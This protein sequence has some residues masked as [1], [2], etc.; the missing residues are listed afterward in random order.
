MFSTT[1]FLFFLTQNIPQKAP[2]SFDCV[3]IVYR[4]AVLEQQKMLKIKKIK[5][6]RQVTDP[7]TALPINQPSFKMD[8]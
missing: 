6:N 7:L 4:K 1:C 8:Q 3:H 5:P 2:L